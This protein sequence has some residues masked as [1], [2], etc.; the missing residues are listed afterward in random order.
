MSRAAVW[1]ECGQVRWGKGGGFWGVWGAQEKGRRASSGTIQLLVVV[2]KPLEWK[3]PC[4]GLLEDDVRPLKRHWDEEVGSYQRSHLEQLMVTRRP[5]VQQYETEDM[6]F[7][8]SDVK[9]FSP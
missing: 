8:I 2:P 9:T 7:R 1:G 4:E 3:G 5:V 6:F